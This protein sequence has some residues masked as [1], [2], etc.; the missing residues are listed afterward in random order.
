MERHFRMNF[1]FLKK[2]SL[3]SV[4]SLATLPTLALAGHSHSHGTD[5]DSSGH[6]SHSTQLA[7]IGVM[8]DH[9]LKKGEVMASAR[10]MSMTMQ[11]HRSG[12]TSLTNGQVLQNFMVAPTQ[13]Q[14]TMDMLGAMWAPSDRL[15]WMLMIPRLELEMDH[16]TRTGA[17]FRRNASGE[18]DLRLTAMHE[19][20]NT[21]QKRVQVNFGLSF[22]TGSI[23]EYHVD[24]TGARI[25]YAYPMQL[26][27]GTYDLHPN[28]VLQKKSPGGWL[29]LQLGGTFRLGRNDLGY[30]LGNQWFVSAWKNWSLPGKRTV[31]LRVHH[32]DWDN[33][34]GVDSRLN[35]AMAPPARADLRGGNR[36]DIGLGLRRSFRDGNSLAFEYLIPVRQD[37]VGP[38]LE[39]DKTWTL[40]WQV[41]F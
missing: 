1:P 13:M 15:T 9:T 32:S 28:V 2:L 12:T 31:S 11:G 8:G 5:S 37:L 40:G 4:L 39:V 3:L 17:R 6:H 21:D 34:D 16:V 24:P 29:G 33:I 27:S 35:P 38:Q 7:P 36:T 26:G 14:M 41:H 30:S 23:H 19:V 25:P 22:P 20:A 10:R 18:G